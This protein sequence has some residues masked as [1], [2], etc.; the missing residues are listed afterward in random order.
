MKLCLKKVF[1]VTI[2]TFCVSAQEHYEPIRFRID[3]FTVMEW[4]RLFPY[5]STNL[6]GIKENDAAN[7]FPLSHLDAY[8]LSLDSIPENYP[9]LT[10]SGGMDVELM[11]SK[12]DKGEN[13]SIKNRGYNTNVEMS[14][15][16]FD[17]PLRFFIGRRYINT[18]THL[19]DSLWQR[20]VRMCYLLS[21]YDKAEIKHKNKGLAQGVSGGYSL[22]LPKLDAAGFVNQYGNWG[23]S[24]YYFFPIYRE[25][26][27]VTQN[28]KGTIGKSSTYNVNLNIDHY[29]RYF[30][31]QNPK[32]FN[33]IELFA[34]YKYKQYS[35]G[36]KYDS[37]TDPTAYFTASIANTFNVVNYSAR[38]RM[39]TNAVIDGGAK[40]KL[41]LPG[42]L[43]VDADVSLEYIPDDRNFSF[44]SC[45]QERYYNAN[46][47]NILTAVL[48]AGYET[49]TPVPVNFHYWYRYSEDD[50]S[51]ELPEY[52]EQ[53]NIVI[54]RSKGDRVRTVRQFCGFSVGTNYE[55]KRF[56]AKL[57]ADGGFNLDFADVKFNMPLRSYVEFTYG[58]Q[59]IGKFYGMLRYEVRSKTTLVDSTSLHFVNH[60]WEYKQYAEA[61][62]NLSL[63]VFLPLKIPFLKDYMQSSL[64]IGD[65]SI[66]LFNESQLA[67]IP[68]G[69]PVGPILSVSL[70][71]FFGTKP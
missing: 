30:D 58:K 31:H 46:A 51:W 71:G 6:Y 22:N 14:A 35:L 50:V 34:S 18:C 63:K 65:E 5:L 19:R 38:L 27:L 29:N 13:S 45:G 44:I 7:T 11:K 66:H 16:P 32:T 60:I 39:F 15:M 67:N 9:R 64:R 54:M 57:R 41:Y 23:Y 61:Q 8:G 12:I 36:A 17:I 47:I 24:P 4:N 68:N 20:H 70:D 28:V 1:L 49:K 10:V 33:D 53:N 55:G 52:N 56:G 2:L 42:N 43:F 62:D 26:V 48:G 59:Q 25:G 21:E 69:S 3:G 37:R 40:A